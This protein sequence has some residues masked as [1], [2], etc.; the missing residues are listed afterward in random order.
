[1]RIDVKK[2]V[3]NEHMYRRHDNSMRIEYKKHKYDRLISDKL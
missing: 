2:T 1:M 3:K